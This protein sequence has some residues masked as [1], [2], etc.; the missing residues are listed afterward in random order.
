M[1]DE[2]NLKL[3]PEAFEDFLEILASAPEP[4][5]TEK[6][7]ALM[8]VAIPRFEG[9]IAINLSVSPDFAKELGVTNRR[10]LFSLILTLLARHARERAQL[11][12]QAG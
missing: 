12:Q 3:S 7:V 8:R 10:E 9:D 2:P 6:L 5:P 1:S 4:E 11:E